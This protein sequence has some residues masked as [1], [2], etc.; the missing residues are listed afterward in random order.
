MQLADHLEI[1][2]RICEF[3]PR[4]KSTLVEAVT[5]IASAIAYCRERS[6]DRLLID[7]T[8]LE[9]VPIPTL[10]DRFLMVEDWAEVAE[11][12]IVVALFV[13]PE[14]IHPEKFGVHVAGAF[15]LEMNVFP[16]ESEALAWLTSSREERAQRGAAG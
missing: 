1:K 7:A 15:G 6:F 5:H 14:Y 12:L 8:G 13:H 16:S 4:G 10:I 9:G 3:R 11:G 2:Q